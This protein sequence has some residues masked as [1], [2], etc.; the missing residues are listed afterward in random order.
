MTFVA[1]VHL[2]LHHGVRDLRLR[3]RGWGWE[4]LPQGRLQP[5]LQIESAQ[6]V[7]R[8]RAAHDFG[9]VAGVWIGL[10]FGRTIYLLY[11]Y[12]ELR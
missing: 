6:V 10:T 1:G 7:G 5:I 12:C 4:D 9:E 2:G 8:L 3:R 11:L